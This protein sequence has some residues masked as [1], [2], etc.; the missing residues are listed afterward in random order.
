MKFSSGTAQNNHVC[1]PAYQ[2]LGSTHDYKQGGLLYWWGIC[3][4]EINRECWQVKKK[5]K[6]KERA[7]IRHS[8]KREK[9]L[10]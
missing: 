4:Q 2:W 8:R 1:R 10:G 7:G 9:L 3:E 5:N 6:N